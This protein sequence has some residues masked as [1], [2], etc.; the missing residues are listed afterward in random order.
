[1]PNLISVDQLVKRGV[2]VIFENNY[3]ALESD[4]NNFSL[5]LPINDGVAQ[6][7]MKGS[8]LLAAKEKTWH[9][10]LNHL[11]EKSLDG[12]KEKVNGLDF[13][14]P[15]EPCEGCLKGKFLRTKIKHAP[16][17]TVRKPLELLVADLVGPFPTSKDKKTGALIVTC[18]SSNY[19]WSFAFTKKSETPQLVKNLIL[20]L[21][22]Q[23]PGKIKFFQSD[24]GLEF[25]NKFLIGFLDNL[26]IERRYSNAYTHEHNGRAEGKNNILLKALRTNLKNALLP[27]AF[28]SYSLLY[29]TYVQ[30]RIC[31]TKAPETPYQKLTGLKPDLSNLRVFGSLGYAQVP[32]L[33][34]KLEDT[35]TK[36]R[37]L[38]IPEHHQGWL[39]ID[40]ASKRV[41]PTAT[42]SLEENK[43]LDPNDSYSFVPLEIIQNEVLT[44][45]EE[46]IQHLATGIPST[47]LPAEATEEAYQDNFQQNSLE[48]TEEMEPQSASDDS[49]EHVLKSSK[50]TESEQTAHET[51]EQPYLNRNFDISTSNIITT[52]RVRSSVNHYSAVAVGAGRKKLQ[53]LFESEDKEEWKKSLRKRA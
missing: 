13:G 24:S 1:M 9:Q 45:S 22:R 4:N 41:F 19:S 14:E 40:L 26:G 47:R 48:V 34:K 7:K 32:K 52:P 30:N 28:W 36:V 43:F 51:E 42:L 8:F 2:S 3:C 46:S 17:G 33:E 39:V 21:E 20:K 38:G 10:T 31:S 6:L 12:L 16:S 53:E 5:H 11:S 35:A 27:P 23:H 29:A 37:V 15:K 49:L 25:Y 44:N 18:A 50:T